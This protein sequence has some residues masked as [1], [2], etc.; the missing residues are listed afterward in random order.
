LCGIITGL[1]S[2]G[3]NPVNASVAGVYL[4]GLSGD[5]AAGIK[6]QRGLIAGDLIEAL[7][8]VIARFEKEK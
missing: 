8:V 2:Q 7:P 5:H 6:G 3:I 4:H 1:I